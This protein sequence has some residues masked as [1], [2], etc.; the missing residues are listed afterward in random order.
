MAKPQINKINPLDATKDNVVSMS[1]VGNLPYS[2]RIVIYDAT[3][4]AV[5]Y[6]NT[7]TNIN[8]SIEHTIPA[9]T[10]TNGKK[11]VVSE[12]SKDIIGL[13]IDYKKHIFGK[14]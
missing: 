8:Y 13:V 6:D 12:S 1:Y 14:L 4:L 7:S 5:L 11:Y 2:N 10:L 3:T 9:N